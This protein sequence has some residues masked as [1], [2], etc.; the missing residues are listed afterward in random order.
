MGLV[1]DPKT[2]MESRRLLLVLK[3]LDP[4]NGPE[5]STTVPWAKKVSLFF[6]ITFVYCQPIFIIFG[7][8]TL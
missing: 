5:S 2:F 3:V 1:A 8:Y 6:A 7:T 4:L